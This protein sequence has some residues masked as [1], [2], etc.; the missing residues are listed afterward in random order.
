MGLSSWALLLGV[1]LAG[2]ASGRLGRGARSTPARGWGQL[3]W[4]QPFHRLVEEA[5]AG[6]RSIFKSDQGN[7]VAPARIVPSKVLE[8][9][10][11]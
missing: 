11:L 10:L 6:R 7:F 1:A 9:Q 5:W 8:K 2:V 3:P 4:G